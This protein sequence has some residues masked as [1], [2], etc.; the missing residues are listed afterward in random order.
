M[1]TLIKRPFLTPTTIFRRE[2]VILSS[3]QGVIGFLKRSDGISEILEENTSGL[4][5]HTVDP[6]TLMLITE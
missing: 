5:E 3:F 2:S 4:S 6:L 1:C